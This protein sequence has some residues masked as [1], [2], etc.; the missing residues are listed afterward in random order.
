MESRVVG[1]NVRAQQLRMTMVV[2]TSCPMLC[3]PTVFT[4]FICEYVSNIC[5]APEFMLDSRATTMSKNKF[6]STILW[7]GW[8]RSSG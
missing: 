4:L 1:N 5:C 3:C 2:D 7:V 8:G 6:S